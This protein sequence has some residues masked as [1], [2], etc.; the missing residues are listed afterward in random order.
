MSET[1]TISYLG[2]DGSYASV[3]ARKLCPGAGYL[4]CASFYSAVQALVKGDSKYAVLPVENTLQGAVTQ[5]LDLLYA[6]PDLYAVRELVLEID[7]RL[8]AAKGTRLED[9]RRV[10]SHQQAI[11]QCGRFL[12]ENLPDA[13]LLY[14][15]S[16]M[17]SLSMIRE[18]GD[19]GIVGSHVTA[20]GLEFIGENIADE[21][22]NFTHFLLIAKG[23][24][25]VPA[26][27][28]R[29]YFAAS[30]PHRP[31]SL[32]AMLDIL[33]KHG[34]NMTKIDSRPIKNMPGEYCFFVE[35]E[36]S[37]GDECVRDALRC[38]YAFTDRYKLLGA[39]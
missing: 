5:N 20:E 34:L 18:P 19:A 36:G 28:A 12:S 7:H 27:S 23:A 35:F 1:T 31:G 4:P 26:E 16:T 15:E 22:K 21:K 2:P 9:V 38:M 8:I 25:N 24:E 29:V 14:T 13:N 6:N 17:Q 37:I 10:Y 32:M 39:Y 3:A 33:S 11:L 30:C